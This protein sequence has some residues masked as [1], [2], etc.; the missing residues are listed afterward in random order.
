ML[1]MS[2]LCLGMCLS[3]IYTERISSHFHLMYFISNVFIAPD[4]WQAHSYVMCAMTHSYA[5][6]ILERAS[7][8][9]GTV[10]KFKKKKVHPIF[11]EF[12]CIHNFFWFI[13]STGLVRGSFQNRQPEVL[14]YC[15]SN[16]LWVCV[17][18]CVCVRACVCVCVCVCV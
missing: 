1:H 9:S 12:N 16:L 2:E 7:H 18:V 6:L 10:T 3:Q 14:P 5:S 8:K 4:L 17:C 13:C 15:W 11:F